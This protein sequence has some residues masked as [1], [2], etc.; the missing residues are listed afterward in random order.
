MLL[1][2]LSKA[3][4][5]AIRPIP[6]PAKW[7]T[8][9]RMATDAQKGPEGPFAQR[10]PSLTELILLSVLGPPATVLGRRPGTGRLP[11]SD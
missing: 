4:L 11:F 1:T 9:Q 10:R 3:G 8:P 6:I 7:G 5:D 2:G